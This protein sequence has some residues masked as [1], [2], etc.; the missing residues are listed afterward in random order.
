MNAEDKKRVRKSTARMTGKIIPYVPSE[1]PEKEEKIDYGAI[2]RRYRERAGFEA[3]AL[4]KALGYSPNAVKNWENGY[5]RPNLDVI[6]KLCRILNMPLEA[7]FGIPG[8]ENMDNQEVTILDVY[9]KL[10]RYN[11]QVMVQTG[12]SLLAMQRKASEE[13]KSRIQFRP[14]PLK[15][16]VLRVSAGYGMTLSDVEEAGHVYVRTDC[17]VDG[18]DWIFTV[19]GDS[20]EPEFHDGDKVMART[21]QTLEEGEIGVFVV[22][23]EGFIKKYSRQGLVSLNPAYPVRPVYDDDNARLIAKVIGIVPAEML[24]TAEQTQQLDEDIDKALFI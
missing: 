9:H 4:S 7:F 8:A 20:M 24:S 23:D 15:T 12:H 19:C 22:N 6:V 5:S 16:P 13:H 3:G 17:P 18:G 21:A 14:A 11:K 10:N 1:T 2:V